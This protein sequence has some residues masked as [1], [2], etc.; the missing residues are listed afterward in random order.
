MEALRRP[1]RLLRPTLGEVWTS[2]A[3]ALPALGALLAPLSTVDLAY[4]VRAGDLMRASGRLLAADPFTFIGDGSAWVDQQWAAQ[5]LLSVVHGLGG[6]PLLALLRALLVAVTFGLLLLAVRGAGAGA[7]PAAVGTLAA[8]LLAAPALSLRAQSFGLLALAVLLVL[9]AWRHRRP[10]LVL[11][12]PVVTLAW[13]NLHGSFV[14]APAVVGAAALDDALAR[15]PAGRM[16][17]LAGATL[18]ATFVTPWGPEVW[19]YASALA[20]SPVVRELVSEWRP[21]DPL[22][23][24]GLLAVGLAGLALVI[25]LRAARRD[26]RAVPWGSI[27]IVGALVALAATAERGVAWAAIVAVA[28]VVPLARGAPSPPTPVAS[29]RVAE[30]RSKANGLV[31]AGLALAIV[32]L[33]PWW[34]PVTGPPLPVL[35][36]APPGAAALLLERTSEGDRL[37]VPQRLAS[38]VVLA[39]PGRLVAVDSRIELFPQEVWDDYLAVAA[40]DDRARAILDRWLVDA[41][42]TEADGALAGL[43]AADPAYVAAG[44]ADGFVLF[45]SRTHPSAGAATAVAS[46]VAQKVG[47]P[48][49]SA[50]TSSSSPRRLD[51]RLATTPDARASAAARTKRTGNGTGRNEATS[52]PA[53]V[54]TIPA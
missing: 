35:V 9:I 38:W 49:T 51:P 6:W 19:G 46:A 47:W 39:V 31:V 48:S 42:L 33:L 29:S 22:G 4:A 44:E 14:L 3:I 17:L 30:R 10:G 7:R 36:D 43:L 20:A 53:R 26:Q 37:L 41:V 16:L 40:G 1:A 21:L 5:V 32:A 2:L 18:L 34:R 45:L 52:P 54:S 12:A 8:F 24:P 50:V 13:A 11:L 15:R 28:T 23:Y 27:G 25:A